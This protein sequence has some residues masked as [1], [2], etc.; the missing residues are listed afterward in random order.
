MKNPIK[1]RKI[2]VNLLLIAVAL[3]FG[4]T[5]SAEYDKRFYRSAIPPFEI[6]IP[7]SITDWEIRG[8]NTVRP[9]IAFFKID[10]SSTPFFISAAVDFYDDM[11]PHIQRLW[12]EP[13]KIFTEKVSSDK[14]FENKR[15][16]DVEFISDKRTTVAA[17][18]AFG[19]VFKSQ[20]SG[21]TYHFVY[22]L[23]PE[24]ILS[25]GLNAPTDYFGQADE[26][27]MSIINTLKRL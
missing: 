22:V 26:D 27:F 6:S 14:N 8:P 23:F 10:D 13:D 19:R 7:E 21:T 16:P 4:S 11:P 12:S 24:G 3:L 9:N 17:L 20:E 18:P 5:V 25:L 2:L 15:L 1:I